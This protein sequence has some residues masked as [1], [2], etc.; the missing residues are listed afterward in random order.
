MNGAL[1]SSLFTDPPRWEWLIVFY[2]F[3]GGIA[4]GAYFLAAIID[5]FGRWE[6]RP[7]ARL[8]YYI[9]LPAVIAS[10]ILLILD[11]SRPLR[12]W[13]MLLESETWLPMFKWWSPMSIGSWA[14]LIFGVFTLGSFLAALAEADRAW[15]WTRGLRWAWTPALRA[16]RPLGMVWTTIGALLGLFVAGYTGVLLAVTNRPVWTD[17]NLLG[18]A[19]L[20]SGASTGAALLI[21]LAAFARGR[22][23]LAPGV[24]VLK[25]FDSWVLVAELIVL[26]ALVISVGGAIVTRAWLTWWGVLF[27]VGVF[28]AGILVPL[29]LEVRRGPAMGMG[30]VMAA[31]LVLVGGF[32]LRVVMLLGTE[33]ISAGA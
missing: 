14:I 5:F 6:D 27:L 32:V 24:E 1:P 12:F 21:L 4:G 28:I 19:F 25:R 18:L 7:L 26:I 3:I 2:F 17:T 29:A 11:L 31:I 16:P 20:L 10:G 15:R 8:G 33:H 9:A 22:R 23:L 30:T 13:H